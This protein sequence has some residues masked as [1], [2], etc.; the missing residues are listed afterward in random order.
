MVRRNILTEED[1]S[2]LPGPRQATILPDSDQWPDYRHQQY[3]DQGFHY[4]QNDPDLEQILRLELAVGVTDNQHGRLV[5]EDLAA[6][7]EGPDH[8]NG[9][10]TQAIGFRETHEQRHGCADI[11]R[12]WQKEGIDETRPIENQCGVIYGLDKRVDS[13]KER[14]VDDVDSFGLY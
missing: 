12:L 5:H 10:R 11:R 8:S 1:I 4:R 7:R 2:H 3:Q 13:R 9:E 14:G 6:G